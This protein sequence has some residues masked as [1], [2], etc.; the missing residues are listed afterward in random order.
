MHP[1]LFHIGDFTVGSYGLM[2]VIGMLGAIFVAGRLARRRGFPP[3]FFQDLAMVALVAGL[4][5]ARLLYVLVNLPHFI[6]HPAEA[7]FSR[8]GFV[9]QGGALLAIA[10]CVWYV[11]R[12]RV[13]LFEAADIAA[14]ALALGHAF[15]RI[16]CF[17]AGCC[18]GLTCGP[19]HDHP[20]LER[21]A[22]QFPLVRDD[23]G[24]PHEMFNF[25]FSEQVERG[26][27]AH[28]A[29]APLPV[30]PVQLLES[31]GN[32]AIFGLL[33]WVWSRRRFSGQVAALYLGLYALL[34]FGVEFIR[35]D[36]ERGLWLGGLISTGQLISLLMLAG[37]LALWF[38]RRN[39]SLEAVDT[40]PPAPEAPQPA[41]LKSTRRPARRR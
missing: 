18:F 39:H 25:A 23:A 17:L 19:G 38:A 2:I 8:G 37:A 15:G 27:I 34:R 13:P 6:N 9:F 5:G 1:V 3:E 11:R 26:L 4:I 22:V 29:S 12:Q 28:N 41:R 40:A 10:A 7:I 32:L 36:I 24:R 35:D 20:I 16:G 31:A 14:P 33:L 30:L 21:F